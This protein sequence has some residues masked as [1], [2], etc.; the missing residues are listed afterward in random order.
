MA[1]FLQ[2]PLRTLYTHLRRLPGVLNAP[3]I[4]YSF[5]YLLLT[6][7]V[8]IASLAAS[9]T[10]SPTAGPTTAL[11]D[12]SFP[13]LL[14]GPG[15]NTDFVLKFPITMNFSHGAPAIFSS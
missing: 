13:L 11:L 3:L 15:I 12:N 8:Y 1:S 6:N 5:N 9:V 14:L 2:V 4:L 10:F 7:N